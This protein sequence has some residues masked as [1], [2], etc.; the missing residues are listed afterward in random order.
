MSGR[1]QSA[2]PLRRSSQGGH[3]GDERIERQSNFKV[4]GFGAFRPVSV[5]IALSNFHSL[6]SFVFSL[7]EIPHT[8]TSLL[9]HYLDRTIYIYID[10]G[11]CP[12]ETT[13]AP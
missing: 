8:R 6:L 12:C 10:V 4:G 3:K 11:G 13:F 2:E 5:I 7:D 9:S 1:R